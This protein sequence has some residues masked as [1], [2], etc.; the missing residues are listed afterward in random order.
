MRVSK[1][2]LD[3]LVG[4]L[5]FQVDLGLHENELLVCC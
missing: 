2:C 5:G 4:F 3:A 1:Y